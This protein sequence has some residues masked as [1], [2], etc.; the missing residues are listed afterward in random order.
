MNKG[1]SKSLLPL[2]EILVAVAIFAIAVVL[3][4]QLFLL[5]RFLGDKTADTARAIFEVQSV[6]ENIKSSSGAEFYK[7]IRDDLGFA[8]S[9]TD[10]SAE[11]YYDANWDRMTGGTK[12]DAEYFMK[13]NMAVDN[14]YDTGSLY[15]FTIEFFRASTYPFIDDQR[16]KDNDDYIPQLVPKDPLIVPKDEY[17]PF[18]VSKFVLN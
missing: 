6:A 7:Y 15:T 8:G 11:L 2:V 16:K 12:D 10:L 1:S 17:S 18:V 5:A 4:L 3:T 14:G 13:I 9:A